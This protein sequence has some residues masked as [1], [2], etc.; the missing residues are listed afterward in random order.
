MNQAIVPITMPRW[1]IEMLRG[2]ITVWHIAPGQSVNKGDALLDVETDKIVNSVEAPVSGVLRAIVAE[3][4]ATADAGALI[5]VI[6]GS[7]IPDEQ[8]RDFIRDFADQGRGS[9]PGASPAA[10]MAQTPASGAS[11]SPIARRLAERLGIDISKVKGSGIN[12]RVSKEDVEAYA[13]ANSVTA[14]ASPAEPAPIREKLSPTRAAIAKRL[15]ESTQGI[16]HYRLEVDVDF[17]ALFDHRASGDSGVESI[18]INDFVIR[19]AA[20]ALMKHPALNA[21]LLG[22]EILSFG[23][24][25]IGIAVVTEKGLITPVLRRAETKT[26]AQIAKETRELANRARSGALTREDITGGSFTIS[27][28]GMFGVDRFDAIIN[29][30]QVA[31]LAVAAA[32]DRPVARDG[33]AAIRKIATLTL[34]ADHRVVDGAAGAQFLA[35]LRQLIESPQMLS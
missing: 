21:N 15:L 11:I 32:A 3:K 10:A 19:A 18:S 9:R 27:N 7:S 34:S 4:G 8:V 5:A 31:I 6:A 30:P 16:P 26:P 28:L 13:A 23:H 2:T 35:S 20:L 14:S 25:D 1:G 29:P 12:G 24:A 17:S 33:K 22:D